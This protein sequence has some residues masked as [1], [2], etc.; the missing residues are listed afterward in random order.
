MLHMRH[1]RTDIEWDE[2]L[3]SILYHQVS[4]FKG[5]RNIFCLFFNEFEKMILPSSSTLTS[6][7]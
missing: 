4:R 6:A 7:H 2:G 1:K 3:S 5:R